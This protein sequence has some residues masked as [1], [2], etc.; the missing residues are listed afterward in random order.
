MKLK[1]YVFLF[2]VLLCSFIQISFARTYYVS[3]TGT[4]AQNT[5]DINTPFYSMKKA[6]GKSD[7]TEIIIRG[8]IHGYSLDSTVSVNKIG[9]GPGAYT[10]RNYP[11]ETVI[12]D[13]SRL[14]AAKKGF[15]VTGKYWHITGITIIKARD[16]GMYIT[17]SDN[18]IELCVFSENED[19]GLQLSGGATRNKIINCD[20]YYNKDAT[21]EN[22]DGFA[23][24]LDV[25]DSNSFKGCR[26][27]QNSDDGW[28]GYIRPSATYNSD[29][30]STTLDS[31]WSFRNG[32][33]KTGALSGVNGDGNGFKMGG[34]DSTNK[35]HNQTLTHCV[36]FY[37]RKRGFDQNNNKGSMTLYNNTAFANGAGNFVMNSISLA[38]GSV[39]TVKNCVAYTASGTAGTNNFVNGAVQQPFVV[40]N[41]DFISI[42][43]VGARGP[44][45]PDGSLPDVNFMHLAEGSDLIDGGQDVGLVFSGTAPDPGAFEFTPVSSI[46]YTFNGD[47]NWDDAA[48]WLNSIVPPATLNPGNQ[49]IINPIDGGQCIVNISYTVSP[50][51]IITVMAGKQLSLPGNLNINN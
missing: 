41:A 17:G 26:S 38:A 18:I 29:N 8:G 48:N 9:A 46:I 42:D 3:T 23:C 44:R 25:G 19:S 6:L 20:S 47:G 39:M 4:D 51:V 36:S 45:K 5:G 2:I 11:G 1:K 37:N 13:C 35:R 34:S 32:Y 22:A 27:W 50:G 16:N 31:C 30:V 10:I 28:D 43:T 33:L 15:S 24:K 21:S 7:M 12:F 14:N 40:S 49:I